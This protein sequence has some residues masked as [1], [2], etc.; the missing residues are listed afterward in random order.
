MGPARLIGAIAAS[1]L[2]ALMIAYYVLSP[3]VFM[4]SL[5]S[6][7]KNDGRDALALD[8]DFPSVRAGLDEQLDA[9][10]AVRAERQKL[11]KENEIYGTIQR[12]LPALGHQLINSIVTPD[13]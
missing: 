4:R 2:V 7:A 6:D 10:L 1:L 8:V 12:F 9:L 3:F 13:G 11:R 5:A